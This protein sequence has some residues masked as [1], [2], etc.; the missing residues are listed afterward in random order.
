M[1]AGA[2]AKDSDTILTVKTLTESINIPKADIKTREK[3]AQS[4]MPPGLL[5]ALS[6]RE[7]LELLKFLTSQP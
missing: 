3:L 5:E 4:F 7:A 1:V 6:E 2:V